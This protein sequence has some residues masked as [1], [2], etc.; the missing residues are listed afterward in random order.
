MANNMIY[1]RGRSVYIL[2]SDRNATFQETA[3][4][5][6]PNGGH[7]P[8]IT[9]EEDLEFLRNITSTPTWLNMKRDNETNCQWLDKV[10][11]NFSLPWMNETSC[12]NE[13]YDYCDSSC[14][15]LVAKDNFM[16]VSMEPCEQNYSAIC[17]AQYENQVSAQYYLNDKK[18]S[19]LKLKD[20]PYV[21]YY[22]N[23]NNE[24]DAGILYI[25]FQKLID[26]IINKMFNDG[27]KHKKYSRTKT[28]QLLGNWTEEYD[29]KLEQVD[30]ILD[31]LRYENKIFKIAFFVQLAITSLVVIVFYSTLVT[32]KKYLMTLENRTKN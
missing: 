15:A 18:P 13:T 10:T 26:W 6:E 3:E 14:C 21:I 17:V 22:E 32:E 12:Q 24:M 31:D 30:A 28:L 4:W 25:H 7:L 8:S 5:C 19:I 11:S 9:S 29:E 16:T 2:N 1:L 27:D 20:G 23:E